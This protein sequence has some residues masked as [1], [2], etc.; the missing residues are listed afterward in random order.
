MRFVEVYSRE[1]ESHN[2]EVEYTYL[3]VFSSTREQWKQEMKYISEWNTAMIIAY[4][5]LNSQWLFE[6][7]HVLARVS[8]RWIPTHVA[9][10]HLER[11]YACFREVRFTGVAAI[12]KST[13]MHVFRGSLSPRAS[14]ARIWSVNTRVFAKS[15]STESRQWKQGIMGNSF[16]GNGV[17]R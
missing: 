13:C 10:A 6:R 5:G 7:K 11:E 16:T 17:A 4:C 8:R 14:R 1:T 12:I 9:G 3:H 15:D 2:K